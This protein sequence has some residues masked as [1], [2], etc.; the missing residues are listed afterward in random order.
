[1][2][3]K[4]AYVRVAERS[5][6]SSKKLADDGKQESSA[7]FSYH[8][9]ESLGGALCSHLATAYSLNH[10]AKINQFMAAAKR[11]RCENGVKKVAIIM[12]SIDRNRCLYPKQE[13][14]GVH[15]L[16][17]NRLAITDAKDLCKR[18]RG[19]VRTIRR[20]TGT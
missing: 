18:V 12:A 13:H 15:S 14:P 5:V 4:S 20:A 2:D 7:F 9:F 16:P 11:A 3:E 8:A 1:M 19:L 17:E 6:L 10:K